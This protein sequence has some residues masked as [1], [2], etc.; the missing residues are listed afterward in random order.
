MVRSSRGEKRSAK[1]SEETRFYLSSCHPDERTPAQWQ[2]LIR[3]H[4]GGVENRNHWRRDALC[5]EDKS[6]TRNPAALANLALV[7]NALFAL[8]P[9]HYPDTPLPQIKERL[10]SR[11]AACLQI[12]RS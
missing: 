9:S 2:A 4:W 12:L 1:S 8:L 6:R 3:G 5:G 7:R 11:P 10:H